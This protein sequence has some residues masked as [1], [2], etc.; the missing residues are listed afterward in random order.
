MEI[1]VAAKP[2]PLVPE[3]VGIVKDRK[4]KRERS[5]KS[6]RQVVVGAAA[7]LGG[8][9][10]LPQKGLQRVTDLPVNRQVRQQ[11]VVGIGAEQ[12]TT[13]LTQA[14]GLDHAVLHRLGNVAQQAVG[15][16]EVRAHR[17]LGDGP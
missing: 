11:L 8:A 2:Q 4:R 16:I 7:V 1:E 12:I 10:T 17:Q 13:K 14:D 6:L 5:Q 15:V 3:L 9:V